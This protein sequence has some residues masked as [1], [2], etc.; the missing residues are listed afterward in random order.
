M[1]CGIQFFAREL[2]DAATVSHI[3]HRSLAPGFASEILV[4]PDPDF[5]L[6][7]QSVRYLGSFVVMDLFKDYVTWFHAIHFRPL[8][9]RRAHRHVGQPSLVCLASVVSLAHSLREDGLAEC[10]RKDAVSA[11]SVPGRDAKSFPESC[12]S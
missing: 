12:R 4:K 10:Y 8:A 7:R 11:N 3:W 1:M 9:K 6:E 5:L 2:G